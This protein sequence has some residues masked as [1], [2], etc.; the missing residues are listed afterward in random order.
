[1]LNTIE[2]ESDE[3]VGNFQ[4]TDTGSTTASSVAEEFV[5]AQLNAYRMRKLRME[6]NGIKINGENGVYRMNF[7]NPGE[8]K[9]PRNYQNFTSG[10][11]HECPNQLK[12]S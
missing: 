5:K 3:N 6:R 8:N 2:E 4:R 12:I 11:S 7:N 10:V 9:N 1:M